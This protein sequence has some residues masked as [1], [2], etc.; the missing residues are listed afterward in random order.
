MS[1]D[2]FGNI[3]KLDNLFAGIEK[4]LEDSQV[5]LS[6]TKKQ[7]HNA[8]SEVAK[9]FLKEEELTEKLERLNQLN[10]ILNMDEKGEN[11]S[12][13]SEPEE[14]RSIR[15]RLADY[16][17]QVHMEEPEARELDKVASL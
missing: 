15:E 6:E 4:K 9:P 8:H 1:S 7:L 13:E 12:E 5:K 10:A 16:K 3:Q 2:P 11:T 17:V 14:K